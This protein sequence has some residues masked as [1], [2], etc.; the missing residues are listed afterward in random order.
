EIAEKHGR[1]N[2]TLDSIFGDLYLDDSW[3]AKFT[4]DERTANARSCF[5]EGLDRDPRNAAC[6][7]GL[8]AIEIAPLTVAGFATVEKRFR[9]AASDPETKDKT[10]ALLLRTCTSNANT[11][12]EHYHLALLAAFYRAIGESTKSIDTLKQA[13]KSVAAHRDPT[14]GASGRDPEKEYAAVIEAWST[15]S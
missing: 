14:Q 7:A 2:A 12:S 8:S 15:G 3:P 1:L 9:Q 5:E 4:I 13:Q 6:I 10:L 11:P